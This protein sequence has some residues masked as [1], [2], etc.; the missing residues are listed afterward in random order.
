MWNKIDKTKSLMTGLFSKEVADSATSFFI[1]F[2]SF[3]EPDRFDLHQLYHAAPPGLRIDNPVV[4]SPWFTPRAISYRP[5]RA[6]TPNPNGV[7]YD[8]PW[9]EPRERN[10]KKSFQP[11]RGGRIQRGP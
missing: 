4:C 1:H 7:T 8:S 10:N 3:T 5:F 2:R 11:Q 9:H 6:H